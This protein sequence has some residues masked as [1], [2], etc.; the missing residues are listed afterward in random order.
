M[1][2]L[3]VLVME[4]WCRLLP[5]E[6]SEGVRPVKAIYEPAEGKRKK[7]RGLG[8]DGHG[9]EGVQTAQSPQAGDALCGGLREGELLDAP[10]Q[11]GELGV[12]HEVGS[13]QMPVRFLGIGLGERARPGPDL[14]A[15]RPPVGTVRI[16]LPVAQEK[17]PQALPGD[18]PVGLDF[19]AHSDEVTRR[20]FSG[21][22]YPNARTLTG[23]EEA[24][25]VA[26][27]RAVGLDPHPGSAG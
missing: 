12:T 25:Q 3:P 23:A 16:A 6:C 27:V 15:V 17:A 18:A 24:H 13:Q 21:A 8:H 2:R 5:L 22:R 9:G 26:G 14:K 11:R 4:P 1:C 19:F 20:L 7:S 10:A